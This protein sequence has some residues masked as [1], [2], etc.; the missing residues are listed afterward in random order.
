MVSAFL[1]AHE[2]MHCTSLDVLFCYAT[3]IGFLQRDLRLVKRLLHD[4][5]ATYV[6][7]AVAG[8]RLYFQ[9]RAPLRIWRAWHDDKPVIR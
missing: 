1:L 3:F 4:L 6:T 7:V 2:V 5:A 9:Q 8:P